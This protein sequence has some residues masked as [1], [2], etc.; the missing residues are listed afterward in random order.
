MSTSPFPPRWRLHLLG[1]GIALVLGGCSYESTLES[2]PTA[3]A[4]AVT[5]GPT[6]IAVGSLLDD[7]SAAWDG[8]KTWTVETRTE[9]SGDGSTTTTSVA[10]E[11]VVLPNERHVVTTNGDTV[12][13]EEIAT[14]GR[15]YMRGTLVTSSIYPE[16]DADTWISFTP[17]QAPADT[18]LAQ[19]V[20]Y[21]TTP[22]G[23]PFATFT[24][25]TRALPAK[26]AGEIEVDDRVC[27]VYHFTTTSQ[28]S[29][30]IDYRVAF[31]DDDRPCQL[32]RDAG[33]VV[34]TTVW[35]YP[36]SPE[37]ISTPKNAVEVKD[38]PG[39]P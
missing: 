13:A 6:D 25:E 23:F 4:T 2:E 35:H 7:A 9:A 37:P 17:D 30:G 15:I 21:L 20:D 8:I 22:P 5:F 12:V 14:G 10:K 3:T 39:A 18:A 19:R 16:V 24:E 29:D 26:P 27:L 33:G 36:D 32:V 34:E 31:D 11:T 38:F 1:L 28:D